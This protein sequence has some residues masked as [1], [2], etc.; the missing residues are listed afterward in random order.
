MQ[1]IEFEMEELYSYKTEFVWIIELRI[2]SQNLS[3]L[4]IKF[5]HICLVFLPC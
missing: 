4:L 5:D 1:S 3:K 2:L